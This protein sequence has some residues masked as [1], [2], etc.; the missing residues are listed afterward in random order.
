MSQLVINYEPLNYPIVYFNY[1]T[2]IFFNCNLLWIQAKRLNAY[3]TFVLQTQRGSEGGSEEG[4]PEALEAGDEDLKEWLV[5]LEQTMLSSKR[6][7][8]PE[9]AVPEPLGHAD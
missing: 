3:Y 7:R 5:T 2:A 4:D 9:N 1:G 6:R 8:T